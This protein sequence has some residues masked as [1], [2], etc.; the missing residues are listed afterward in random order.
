MT[1][2]KIVTNRKNVIKHVHISFIVSVLRY[3]S[4][5]WSVG[6]VSFRTMRPCSLYD[7]IVL[8]ITDPSDQ[9]YYL[10]FY[11]TFNRS[12]PWNSR[13]RQRTFSVQIHKDISLGLCCE[14]FESGNEMVKG[15]KM[16]FSHSYHN[17]HR[18]LVRWLSP[19]Y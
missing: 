15:R 3:L 6:S 11:R 14:Y 5:H 18:F 10:R 8:K 12:N 13:H 17:T 1:F 16:S 4:K 19:Q 9:Y 7:L 2:N